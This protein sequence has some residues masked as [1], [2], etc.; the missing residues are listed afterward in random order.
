MR[1]LVVVLWC[2]LVVGALPV[3]AQKTA[4]GGFLPLTWEQASIRAARENKLVFVDVMMPGRK[5][6][7]KK[8]KAIF[9][10]PQVNFFMKN[11]AI[12][13][14]MDMGTPEGAE[15]APRL[16]MNM[17]PTYAFFMPYGDLLSIAS[18]FTVAANPQ[19]LVTAGEKAVKMAQVKRSNSRSIRFRELTLPEALVKAG[20]EG[21]MVFID[22][23]TD[24]CQPCLMMEKHI[25]SLDSV[26]DFYNR[27]FINI[28][29]HFGKAKEL[30]EK[31]AISGYPSF[32]FVNQE[33]KLVHKAGGY[34]PAE[35][36]I[37]YGQEALRKAKG[38]AFRPLTR[39]DALAEAKQLQKMVFI[40]VFDA[41]DRGYKEMQKS[42]FTDP[43]VMDALT[44]H[45]VN[46]AWENVQ[47]KDLWEKLQL[48]TL[49]AFVVLDAEGYEIHRF[50]GNT[51]T[52]GMLREVR[53]VLE[54]KGLAAM[55]DAYGA[56]NRK[57][58]FV[59]EYIEVLGRAGDTDRAGKVTLEYLAG[60]DEGALKEKKYWDLF[61]RFVTDADSPQFKYV[62]AR[63]GEFYPL[64]GQAAVDRKMRE[65]W[66]AGAD[67]Y[68]EKNASGYA[69]D[70]TGLKLY[71]KRM[72]K[73]KVKDWRGIVRNTRMLAAEKTGNWKE[74]VELA[75]EKW[76]EEDISDA[77]LYSWG[78]K[79]NR[80]C[81]DEGT[82]FKA[83]R[84]FALAASQM[85][86][87][88]R[89]SGKVNI[90]SYKSFFE[91]LVDDL[92]GKK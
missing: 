10:D 60:M 24:Y 23:Y 50:T 4:G 79:I 45:F 67:R 46:V 8:E 1:K 7:P 78:V 64:F 9:S 14:R 54:G 82:R 21:K 37:G 49:P 13:I 74:Y 75:E 77:E 88:E 68:V 84:W 69:L 35:Q 91:K 80:E 36:F 29:L 34:S 47:Q 12:M 71:I 25:F 63:R 81:R 59:E 89:R 28:K 55:G 6:D 2:C 66:A 90:T 44:G 62:Y 70:E 3:C 48:K 52:A 16:M 18:P 22:A 30:A 42:V 39:E 32:L 26:A 51:D 72:K 57:A 15:F 65:V 17:Y 41:A 61:S 86:Q 27:N 38:V 73:E 87:Q 85:E 83:A 19:V 76:N 5:E 31:Y 20:E 92:V 58:D 56:G 33:G 43:G 40:S 11:N 53:N